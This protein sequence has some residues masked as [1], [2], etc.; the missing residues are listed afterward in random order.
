[1]SGRGDLYVNAAGM[2]V[3]LKQDESEQLQYAMLDFCLRVMSDTTR[4]SDA[5]LAILPLILEILLA[6]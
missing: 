5:E 2:P 1:M 6:A 4:K 3:K